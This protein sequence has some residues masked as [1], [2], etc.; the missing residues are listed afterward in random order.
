MSNPVNFTLDD[1]SV[2]LTVYPE[3]SVKIS[4]KKEEKK[5]RLQNGDIQIY[6]TG[7]YGKI[8]FKMQYVPASDAMQIND[9]WLNNTELTY[10]HTNSITSVSSTMNCVLRNSKTPFE[11]YQEPYVNLM[12]G[13]IKLEEM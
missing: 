2:T 1:G 13:S 10:T 8:D 5:Y 7:D 11:R 3:Y 12:E 4:A 6:K 9:W